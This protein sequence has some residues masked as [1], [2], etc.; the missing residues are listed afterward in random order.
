MS[1]GGYERISKRY[2]TPVRAK[3]LNLLTDFRPVDRNEWQSRDLIIPAAKL[4]ADRYLGP[5]S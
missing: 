3:T 4:Y 2:R 5:K 1:A